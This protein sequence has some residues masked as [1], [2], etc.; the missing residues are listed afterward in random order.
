MSDDAKITHEEAAEIAQ[1]FIDR[2]FGNKDGNE[3]D[4]YP[5]ISIPARP[6]RDD[7][8]RLLAYIEQ[9]EARDAEVSA[10]RARLARLADELEG[11]KRAHGAHH[12]HENET[13]VAQRERIAE[14]ER[15]VERL[16]ASRIDLV[17]AAQLD[18]SDADAR[19]EQARQEGYER[20]K[21]SVRGKTI[22]RAPLVLPGDDDE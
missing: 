8:I 10:L 3:R 2:H 1:R 11:E 13:I 5:R 14:L 4:I 19:I 18:L 7:D 17:S 6:R 15:E 22:E 9:Q 16:R 21:A 12:S 20:G